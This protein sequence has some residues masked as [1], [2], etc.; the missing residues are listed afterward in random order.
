MK[1]LLGL[2]AA[3]ASIALLTGCTG[4]SAPTPTPTASS[5]PTP[6]YTAMSD[7][8]AMVAFKKVVEDSMA[9][10]DEVGLT[11]YTSNSKYG[12]Y[13]LVLSR[14]YNP[15]HQAAVR[16]A[17]GT[18]ELIWETSAFSAFA[19]AESLS[20]GA[21]VSF[22][23]KTGEFIM[24]QM[25]EGTPYE[26][27]YKVENGIIVGEYGKSGDSDWASIL[28]YEVTEDGRGII[29]QAVDKLNNG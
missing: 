8:E 12:D 19:A 25:I 20:Y 21:G 5:T 9:K 10:A 1:K 2:A 28:T 18:V 6:S 27:R 3:A 7:A 24:T 16:N 14:T 29:D 22:D 26:Y 11:E 15:D 17:D 13:V 23:S 4:A